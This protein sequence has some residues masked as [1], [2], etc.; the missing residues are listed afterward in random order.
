MSV[1]VTQ[2]LYFLK[3]PLAPRTQKDASQHSDS[4]LGPLCL[5]APNPAAGVGRAA[6]SRPAAA[7]S[8]R[9]R[10]GKLHCRVLGWQQRGRG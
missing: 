9:A 7:G 6:G 3:T 2:Q 1:V 4:E 5:P 8:A 10:A